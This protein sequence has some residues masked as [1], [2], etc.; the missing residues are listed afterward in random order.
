MNK[1]SLTYY[2]LATGM[3]GV[4]DKYDIGIYEGNTEQEA[5]DNYINT[6]EYDN[7]LTKRFVRS[8]INAKQIKEEE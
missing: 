2:Y 1:Y 6:L 8:C 7:P 3:E 5:I 4:A